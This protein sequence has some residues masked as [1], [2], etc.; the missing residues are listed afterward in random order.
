[1]EAVHFCDAT[2]PDRPLREALVGRGRFETMYDAE[3][4]RLLTAAR[5]IV[6]PQK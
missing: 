5:P 1:V 3:L 6:A 2:D 4:V